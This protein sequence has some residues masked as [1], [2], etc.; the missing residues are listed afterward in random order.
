MKLEFSKQ[1]FKWEGQISGFIKIR[2]GV[3]ESLDADRRT[4]M[5]KLIVAFRNAPKNDSKTYGSRKTVY[6]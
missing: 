3:A 4:D 5:T 6:V 2:P 1:I